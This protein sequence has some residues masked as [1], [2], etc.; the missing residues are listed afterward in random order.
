MS[1]VK[2][3]SFFLSFIML[4]ESY[5]I[6]ASS[7]LSTEEN[8]RNIIWGVVN[9]PD[10]IA[11]PKLDAANHVIQDALDSSLPQS[12]CPECSFPF[13]ELRD[14]RGLCPEANT[15]SPLPMCRSALE[16]SQ[17]GYLT[18]SPTLTT[19]EGDQYGKLG[20]WCWQ[21]LACVARLLPISEVHWCLR[22]KRILVL[23]GGY[24]C[25]VIQMVV[26]ICALTQSSWD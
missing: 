26:I 11:F 1:S 2:L 3:Q 18:R 22:N 10:I 4:W 13:H 16:A 8:F 21:P 20:E 17:G 7:V 14:L 19:I 25:W 12:G 15:T 24:S 6:H 23:G 5:R 9:T